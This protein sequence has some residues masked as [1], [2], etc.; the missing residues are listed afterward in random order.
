MRTS[1]RLF[2][3]CGI[4][5][6]VNFS[7]LI[8]FVLATF[9]LATGGFP[10]AAK[11]VSVWLYWVAAALTVLLFFGSVLAHELA[12]SLVARA[13]GLPVKSI[14]LFIF[15]GVSNIE[16]EPQSAGVEFQMAFV[17][18]LTSLLI[19][20]VMLFA[21]FGLD[22]ISAAP[23]LVAV[24]LY[25]G[26]ANVML[27]VFNLIPGFPMDGGRV[28]RSI[29]WKATGSLQ[30]ATRWAANVGQGVAYLMIVAGVWLFF[31]VNVIDGLWLGFIGL[32]LLQA[33]QAESMQVRLEAGLAGVSVGEVMVAV[34]ADAVVPAELPV[35]QLVDDF[36]LRTGQRAVPVVD[37]SSGRQRL[38]GIV[39]LRDVRHLPRER[40][41]GT[42]VGQV[43]TPLAKLTTA[44]PQQQVRDVL[45]LMMQVGV[46]QLPVLYD[47]QLVGML[48]LEAILRRF[49]LQRDL[50]M[51]KQPSPHPALSSDSGHG[52]PSPQSPPTIELPKA[53]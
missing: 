3:L 43:M 39:T 37:D 14:T 51:G 17:G 4:S 28:L 21:T 35:Q 38:L 23:L 34:P 25:V 27:A 10:S 8:I 33:A 13:R 7:W 46:N 53:G 32:F 9:S 48:T 26:F 47:G 12:H 6:E 22:A 20:V 18:P 15:G 41:S 19:G 50:G 31:T 16:R 1:L 36:I 45:P 44:Q 2:T 42:P 40:W 29:I 52:A 11:G 49:E 30:R 5:I 24:F